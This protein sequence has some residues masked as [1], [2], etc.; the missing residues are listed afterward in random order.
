[1]DRTGAD[2]MRNALNFVEW[3]GTHE[4]DLV[5]LVDESLWLHLIPIFNAI[6]LT[7]TRYFVPTPCRISYKPFLPHYP[8]LHLCS[9]PFSKSTDDTQRI[10]LRSHSNDHNDTIPTSSWAHRRTAQTRHHHQPATLHL[11][12]LSRKIL[13]IPTTSINWSI[14]VHVT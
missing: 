12:L 4:D 11:H 7:P 1:M 3:K 6:I 10:A 13:T 9:S 14:N 5:L 2:V 8:R